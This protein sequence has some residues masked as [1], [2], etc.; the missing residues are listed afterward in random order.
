[1]VYETRH[2]THKIISTVAIYF[3]CGYEVIIYIQRKIFFRRLIFLYSPCP[4][5]EGIKDALSYEF[6][7]LTI[8]QNCCAVCTNEVA[9]A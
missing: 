5:L 6:R 8:G 7:R 4:N 1:M 3:F 2:W 9:K